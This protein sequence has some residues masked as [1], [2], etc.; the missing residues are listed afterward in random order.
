MILPPAVLQHKFVAADAG[1]TRRV[2]AD[3]VTVKALAADTGGAYSLFECRTAPAQGTLP[4]RQRYEE[5]TFYVLEGTYTFVLDDQRIEVH[6]GDYV[7]VPRGTIHAFTNTGETVGRVLV[8]VTPGGIHERFFTELGE[9]VPPSTLPTA[10]PGEP[11][12]CHIV[13]VAQK[14]GIEILPPSAA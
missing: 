3:I 5:E 4:H 13:A 7:F 10:P 8:L 12:V 11:D 14:Y 9:P 1:P 6:P 2:L